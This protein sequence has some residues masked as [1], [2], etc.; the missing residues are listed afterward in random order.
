MKAAT[1]VTV[2]SLKPK[3]CI[4]MNFPR[5]K[6]AELLKLHCFNLFLEDKKVYVKGSGEQEP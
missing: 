1:V 2:E 4:V 6:V 3:C 5:T